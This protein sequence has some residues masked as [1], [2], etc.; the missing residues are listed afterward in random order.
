M[1][2]TDYLITGTEDGFITIHYL[3]GMQVILNR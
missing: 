2:I 1:F 3:L